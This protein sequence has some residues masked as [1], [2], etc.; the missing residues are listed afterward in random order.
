MDAHNKGCAKT[1]FSM[2]KKQILQIALGKRYFTKAL[3]RK[4]GWERY[5]EDESYN[6]FIK[7]FL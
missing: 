2:R 7:T 5:L 4:L 1:F 6:D 3:K